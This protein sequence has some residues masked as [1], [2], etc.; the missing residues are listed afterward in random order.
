LVAVE[1]YV[2]LCRNSLRSLREIKFLNQIQVAIK[3][4]TEPTRSEFGLQKKVIKA[5]LLYF[6]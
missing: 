5:K 4:K 3:Q 2:Y 1:L 6:D